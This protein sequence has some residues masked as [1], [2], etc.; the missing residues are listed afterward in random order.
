MPTNFLSCAS[1]PD[2]TRTSV[3]IYELAMA[4]EELARHPMQNYYLCCGK[5]IC[6][7]CVYSFCDSGNEGKCPFCNAERISKTDEERNEELMKRVDVKNDAGAMCVLAKCYFNGRGGLH[8]DMTKANELFARAANLGSSTAHNSLGTHYSEVGD[9]KKAKFHLEAAAMAGHELAR[10]NLG[11][12]DYNFGNKEQ[13]LKHWTIAASAGCYRAM[14]HLRTCFEQ[15]FVSR[16]SIDSTLTA[17]NNSCTEMRSDA[18]DA[19]IQFAKEN[20]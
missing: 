13:A 1:L 11:A 17:Y 14:H 16:E 3:P 5:S 18:R 6:T 12:M 4:N 20:I 15:G 9:L 2:A 10:F 19:Y 8:Q 7:G